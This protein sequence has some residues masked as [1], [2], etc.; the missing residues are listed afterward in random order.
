MNMMKPFENDIWNGAGDFGGFI[1]IVTDDVMLMFFVCVEFIYLFSIAKC[2]W[3][4]DVE[5][6]EK[7]NRAVH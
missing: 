5:I 2:Y 3:V 4:D 6:S 7:L 1:T